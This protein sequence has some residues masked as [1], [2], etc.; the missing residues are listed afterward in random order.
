MVVHVGYAHQPPEEWTLLCARA[1]AVGPGTCRSTVPHPTMPACTRRDSIPPE[2]SQL[3]PRCHLSPSLLG[4]LL[5]G[6]TQT[7]DQGVI[8]CATDASPC[9][10]LTPPSLRGADNTLLCC[11]SRGSLAQEPRVPWVSRGPC[12]LQQ[13]PALGP[14]SAP[15][16]LHWEQSQVSAAKPRWSRAGMPAAWGTAGCEPPSQSPP[17]NPPAQ[18]P[19]AHVLLWGD[20]RQ[21]CAQPRGSCRELPVPAPAPASLP[22][23]AA[24]STLLHQAWGKPEHTGWH[25]LTGPWLSPGAAVCGS[26][27]AGAPRER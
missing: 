2:P 19:L 5:P 1:P 15:R 13:P 4:R 27:A 25:A 7:L 12:S 11:R 21:R 23:G 8:F 6:Q 26:M 3:A 24:R 16:G 20:A 18:D 17:C 9:S 22:A 14:S 10:A